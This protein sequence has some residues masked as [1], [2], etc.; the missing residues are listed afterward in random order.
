RFHILNKYALIIFISSLN[1]MNIYI[2]ITII[3]FII[4]FYL[5]TTTK[6]NFTSLVDLNPLT[7]YDD[8]GTFNFILQTDDLPYWN[9]TYEDMSDNFKTYKEDPNNFKYS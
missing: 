3:I 5:I 2:V 9:P 1:I 8:Y 7:T 4:I 6:E